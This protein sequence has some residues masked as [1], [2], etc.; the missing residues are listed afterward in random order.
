V[1]LSTDPAALR[2]VIATIERDL[3]EDTAILEPFAD[4]I[5]EMSVKADDA[6][7]SAE[8]KLDAVTLAR[9]TQEMTN[10]YHTMREHIVVRLL[11]IERLQH[12]Q[13]TSQAERD[14]R[15]ELTKLTSR[16]AEATRPAPGNAGAPMHAVPGSSR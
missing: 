11:A 16:L 1:N 12:A 6:F 7:A 14:H 10:T 15:T 2:D 3:E 8:P 13:Q 4:L 5:R 9:M